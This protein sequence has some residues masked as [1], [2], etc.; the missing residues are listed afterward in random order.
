MSMA[1]FAFIAMASVLPVIQVMALVKAIHS[2]SMTIPLVAWASSLRLHLPT[3]ASCT[4]RAKSVIAIALEN[5]ARCGA[6][7][8]L[9]L[10]IVI[11]PALMVIGARSLPAIPHLSPTSEPLMYHDLLAR[12][13]HKEYQTILRSWR[14]R[15]IG[16]ELCTTR[17]RAVLAAAESLG[18]TDKVLALNESSFVNRVNSNAKLTQRRR[19]IKE[20]CMR[21]TTRP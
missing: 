11:Q 10:T 3:L 12:L 17:R 5:V 19:L 9:T 18:L 16:R 15:Q 21:I 7:G 20:G 2:T 8:V 1:S 4:V 13:L 14:R 6:Y